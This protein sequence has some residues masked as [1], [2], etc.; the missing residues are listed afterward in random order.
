MIIS[1]KKVIKFARDNDIPVRIGVNWG[2][3]DK[4]IAQ[5]LMDR[6]NNSAHPQSSAVVLRT[7]LVLSVLNNARV[8]EDLGLKKHRFF[9]VR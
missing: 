1:L 5:A 4:Y 8:A 2:S 7:A 9:L 6:N 3:L